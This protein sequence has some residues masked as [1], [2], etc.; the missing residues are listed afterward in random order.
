MAHPAGEAAAG[1]ETCAPRAGAAAD[2]SKRHS[3]A[4][5]AD[6]RT[7]TRVLCWEVAGDGRWL[8]GAAAASSAHPKARTPSAHSGEQEGAAEMRQPAGK[9]PAAGAVDCR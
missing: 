1:G 5:A 2:A 9:N 3:A 6:A 7:R 8:M 4:E